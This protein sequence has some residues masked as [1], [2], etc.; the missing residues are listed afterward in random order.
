MTDCVAVVA[1]VV[2]IAAAVRS[3]WSPCG[4]SM[5][6]TITPFGERAKAHR[7]AGTATWFVVGAV[8]GG[9]TLGVGDGAAGRRRRAPSH[10][11]GRRRPG[12]CALGAGVIAAGLRRRR[13]QAGALPGPPIARSGAT[14]A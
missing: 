4:L 9:L 10:L 7:Y 12:P 6:S 2:A 5:L 3:T 13:R 11:S 14:M 1:A 8:L